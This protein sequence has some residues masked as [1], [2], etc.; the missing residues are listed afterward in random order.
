MIGGESALRTELGSLGCVADRWAGRAQFWTPQL[1]EPA[2]S[3][4][5]W[6]ASRVSGGLG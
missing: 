5:A 3:L 1:C 6:L 4:G 2:P